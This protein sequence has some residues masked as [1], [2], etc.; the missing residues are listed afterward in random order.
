[1]VAQIEGLNNL[2][3]KYFVT[4]LGRLCNEFGNR[5]VVILV[6]NI[7]YVVNNALPELLFLHDKFNN[8]KKKNILFIVTS[9]IPPQNLP[10]QLKFTYKQCINSVNQRN[11]YEL[12]KFLTNKF[13]INISMSEQDLMN[14]VYQNFRNHSNYDVFQVVKACLDLRKQEGGRLDEVDRTTLEKALR[15]VPGSL[16]PQIVQYYNL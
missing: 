8:N 15:N 2:K 5:P 7:D 11:K 12:F 6:K 3:I 14:F 13:G 9:T 10:N 4:E 1:M 16:S